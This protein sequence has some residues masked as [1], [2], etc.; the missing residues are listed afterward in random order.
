VGFPELASSFFVGFVGF[1]KWLAN[2]VSAAWKSWFESRP[3]R[4][5]LRIAS[6]TARSR[7]R[8][9]R[10][11]YGRHQLRAMANGVCQLRAAYVGSDWARGAFE[12]RATSLAV[13]DVK[14]P[15]RRY[16]ATEGIGHH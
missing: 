1:G 9:L 13:Q 11:H 6:P 8:M 4:P 12:V 16:L 7:S 10:R 2:V 5:A 14:T 3:I 15:L